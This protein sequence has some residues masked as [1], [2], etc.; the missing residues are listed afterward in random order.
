MML[1]WR[2]GIDVA[3]IAFVEDTEGWAWTSGINTI[4]NYSP[5]VEQAYGLDGMGAVAERSE[6]CLAETPAPAL[7]PAA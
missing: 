3:G 4:S 2:E 6:R 7:A 1:L 5:D